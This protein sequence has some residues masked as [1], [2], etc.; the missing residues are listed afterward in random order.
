MVSLKQRDD[1]SSDAPDTADGGG[2]ARVL[3]V[4]IKFLCPTCDSKLRTEVQHAGREVPCS[5]CRSL[6]TVPSP[7][8]GVSYPPPGSTRPPERDELASVLTTDEVAFL[9]GN[10]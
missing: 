9:T 2:E 7:F 6:L 3:A 8:A 1:A 4:E 10:M 5:V